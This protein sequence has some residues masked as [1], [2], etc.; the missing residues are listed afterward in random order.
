LKLF[1]WKNGN[2]IVRFYYTA[3][4]ISNATSTESTYIVLYYKAYFESIGQNGQLA[5]LYTFNLSEILHT[6]H[7]II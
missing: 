5:V 1:D 7:I 4:K 2:F 6:L 3:I